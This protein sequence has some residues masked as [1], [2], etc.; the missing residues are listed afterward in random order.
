[1]KPLLV[2]AALLLT[3]ACKEIP[4]SPT[5]PASF[6]LAPGDSAKAENARLT[7]VRV[8]SD[9]RCPIDVVCIQAGDAVIV[10]QVSANGLDGQYE[11]ALVDPSRQSVTHRGYVIALTKLE[12]PRNSQRQ[13]NA[14]D[15]RATIE[16][17]KP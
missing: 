10:V 9:S 12:P 1:M 16:I 5:V 11:L 2:A 15:Y 7:F 6:T 17:T 13:P 8:E 14:G 3:A 4:T